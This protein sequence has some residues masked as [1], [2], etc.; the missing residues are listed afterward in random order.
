MWLASSVSYSSSAWAISSSVSL[1]VEDQ[2]LGLGIGPIDQPLDLGV[3]LLGG[4]LGVVAGAGNV[5]GQ[6]DL[7]LVIAVFDHAEFLAHAPLAD[8]VAREIGGLADV[9]GGA[10]GHVAED[11]SPRRPGRPS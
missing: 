10:V 6:E 11:E 5:A 3:D 8:H 2:A 9:A 4:G 1:L 7:G